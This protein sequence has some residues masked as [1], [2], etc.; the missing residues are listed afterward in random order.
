MQTQQQGQQQPVDVQQQ[1]ASDQQQ[2]PGHHHLQQQQQ[3][4]GQQTDQQQAQDAAAAAANAAPLP[5]ALRARILREAALVL[6]FLHFDGEGC[7]TDRPRA[8]AYFRVA[9]A[10]GCDEAAKTLGWILNTG[11]Y[12]E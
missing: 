9:A 2:Q 12:G 7:A 4:Q 1:H 11:Q 10:A 6:G 3:L 5:E 8:C